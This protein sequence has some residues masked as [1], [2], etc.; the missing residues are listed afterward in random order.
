MR[1]FWVVAYSLS[2]LGTKTY[3]GMYV[4]HVARVLAEPTR[5]IEETQTELK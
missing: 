2:V 5:S 3:P 4:W 1:G